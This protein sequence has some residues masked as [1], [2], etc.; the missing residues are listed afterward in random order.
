MSS[1]KVLRV[2]LN[3]NMKYENNMCI[4]WTAQKK[5]SYPRVWERSAPYMGKDDPLSFFAPY[6]TTTHKIAVYFVAYNVE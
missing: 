5:P 3:E 6:M 4:I 2:F 1:V